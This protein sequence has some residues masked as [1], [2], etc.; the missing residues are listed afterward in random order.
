MTEPSHHHD[1]S[2]APSDWITRFA[3]LVPPDGAVLDLAAG[4]GRHSRHFLERGHSLTAVDRTIEGLH[5]LLN[6][7][8]AE[9]LE[10]DLEDGSPLPLPER[11]FDGVV[12]TNYLYRPILPDIVAAVASGGILLY[13]TF[14]L[15]NERFGRPRNPDFLLKPG[16]LLDAVAGHLRVL[17]YEDLI[18]DTPAPAAVQR[19]CAQREA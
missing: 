1:A 15:G 14:A 11:I 17:A 2:Q 19:I 9:V 12:V 18:V 13:E 5:D 8:R 16:E 6:A 10:H 7:D 3:P 4:G